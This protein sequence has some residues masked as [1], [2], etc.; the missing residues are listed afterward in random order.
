MP[1]PNMTYASIFK[2]INAKSSSI[3]K[4]IDNGPMAKV[5]AL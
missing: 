4:P 2:T 5:Y 3:L 1:L